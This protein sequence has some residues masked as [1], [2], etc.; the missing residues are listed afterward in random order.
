LRRLNVKLYL[1]DRVT[2]VTPDGV[3][4]ANK[5]KIL[6]SLVVWAAGIKAP[7]FLKQIKDI[8][9]NNINQIVVNSS[10]QSISNEHI[11]AFGDCAACPPVVRNG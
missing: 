9:T 1:G 5:E 4:T 7:E 6:S 2:K 3:E 11:F 8:Q 10:L